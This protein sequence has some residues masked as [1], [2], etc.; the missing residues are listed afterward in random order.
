MHKQ[1]PE[2]TATIIYLT[3]DYELFFK[4]SGTPFKCLIQPTNFLI[5]LFRKHKIKATFFIDVLYYIRLLENNSTK[6]DAKRIRNQLCNLLDE[7]HSI[8]LHLHPHWLDAI[9]DSPSWVFPTYRYYKLQNFPEKIITD[10]FISGTQVLNEIGNSIIPGYKVHAFRAGG[11]CIL[12]FE[13]LK[14]GFIE[15]GITIDSSI[16]PG[17]K[18]TSLGYTFDFT[19]SP[20]A[21]Y[22]RFEEDPLHPDQNGTFIEMPITTYSRGIY[23]KI[24]DRLIQKEKPFGDGEF[25]AQEKKTFPS[26]LK[27]T[28]AMLTIESGHKAILLSQIRKSK[29]IN[30]INHPKNI[31]TYSLKLIEFL[32]SRK[33]IFSLLNKEPVS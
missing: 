19:S 25:I 24:L 11:F 29:V 13:K 14:K 21:D 28:T 17:M 8:E 33:C 6:E 9:Y 5:N 30:I 26:K 7:G 4:L 27:H 15:S 32:S 18:A 22:W 12:P 23:Y 1:I 2:K 16:A 10:L 31:T 3:F 20:K